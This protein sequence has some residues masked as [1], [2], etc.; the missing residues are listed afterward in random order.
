METI[1]THRIN[2]T[3]MFTFNLCA[4]DGHDSLTELME[5]EHFAMRCCKAASGLLVSRFWRSIL[6]LS[7]LLALMGCFIR[8]S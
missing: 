3:D 5:L 6:L 4:G 7:N 1:T 2:T 8:Q